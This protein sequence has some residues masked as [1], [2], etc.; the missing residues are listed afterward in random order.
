M[1][2]KNDKITVTAVGADV[3]GFIGHLSSHPD[4][5]D[6]ARERLNRAR[7]KSLITDFNVLR[8][9]DDLGLV[10]AHRNGERSSEVIDLLLN[11]LSECS[12]S[13]E[14]LKL[15]R[16]GDALGKTASGDGVKA[17]ALA[18]MEFIERESE[19]VVCFLANKVSAG[20]WNLPVYRIFA[21]PFNTVGLIMD[22]AMFEGFSFTI[23][24]TQDG[25]ELSLKT[26]SEAHGLL[27]LIGHTSRYVITSVKSNS[28]DDRA[29]VVSTKRLAVVDSRGASAVCRENPIV[30]IRC[31]SGLPAVGET[32][33]AFSTPHLVAG[34]MRASHNGPLMPVPF[35]EANPSRFDGPARVIGAGFQISDG[36]LI[37]PHDLFDDPSFD[38]T[39]KTA[40]LITD[41]LRRHGPFEPHRL[42]PSA[43]GGD[44]M[45]GI[46]GR[47]KDRFR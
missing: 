11:T 44:R 1:A 27:A 37:G 18:E 3:G 39:R 9:G 42:P 41:Y 32:L 4:V 33:E 29:A 10:L 23:L 30:L 47:I 46:L 45:S 19:P 22:P 26:P 17:P 21:D 40:N 28:N 7:E 13:A 34:W 15:H 6:T 43:T 20:A 25:R 35:Y 16:A 8:C 24:D 2:A 5:L 31:Q 12:K 14:G 38:E 36:R